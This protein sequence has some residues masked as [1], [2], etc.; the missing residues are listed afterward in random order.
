MTMEKSAIYHQ[1]ESV[2]AF[3]VALDRIVIRLRTKKDDD[4]SKVELLWTHKYS[5][6]KT[7]PHVVE[8]HK[9]GSDLEHDYYEVLLENKDTRIQYL[10]RI[11]DASGTTVLYSERGFEN[12]FNFDDAGF[13]SFQFGYVNQSDI[14]RVVPKFQGRVFYQIFPD[15]FYHDPSVKPVRVVEWDSTPTNTNFCGGNIKGITAKLPYLERLGIGG[16]YLTPVFKGDTNHKYD[17]TAYGEVDPD[18]GSDEDLKEL[19]REAHKKNILVVLDLVFNHTSFHHPFFQDC[20][21][22]GKKSPYYNWYIIR[23]E[24]PSFQEG[25]YEAFGFHHYMPKINLNN[26]ECADY[27]TNVALDIAKKFGVDGFRLDV[28][29]EV[30]HSFWRKL[31]AELRR[32][33]P[34]FMLIGEIWHDAEAFVNGGD[35][36]DSTMNYALTRECTDYFAL[37]KIDAK[38]FVGN[39]GKVWYRYKD[40][41]NLNLLN[42]LSSHDKTRWLN[43]C[44]LDVKAFLSGYLFELFYPGIPCI[45]YGDEVGLL[46]EDNIL[47]RRCFPWDKSKQNLLIFE[48]MTRMIALRRKYKIGSGCYRLYEENGMA[49]LSYDWGDKGLLLSFNRT[50][51][52]LPLKGGKEVFSLNYE[53]G[54]LKDG[55]F[56]VFET[57]KD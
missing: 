37:G 23:G 21:K 54:V 32:F 8:M 25:N 13:D 7:E 28:A 34:D 45:Y 46:G 51:K 57:S 40:P 16:M 43:D 29:D 27:F 10:F 17:S 47:C 6:N 56:V 38:T 30:A 35:Q 3:P 31:H 42:L 9:G 18:F 20:I 49:N 50:G 14:I 4:I 2:L 39:L 41:V 48:A 33:N 19:V 22:N 1:S 15:R 12:S 11:T 36:F 55:G 26:P 5:K 53:D 52:D 24:K 44:K